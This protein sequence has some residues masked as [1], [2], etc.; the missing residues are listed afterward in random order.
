MGFLSWHGRQPAD[1][2]PC[3]AKP[4]QAEAYATFLLEKLSRGKNIL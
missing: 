4:L 3:K 1:F 2:S